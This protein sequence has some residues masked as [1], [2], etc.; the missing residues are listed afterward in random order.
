MVGKAELLFLLNDP[1]RNERDNELDSGRSLCKVDDCDEPGEEDDASVVFLSSRVVTNLSSSAKSA[2]L[3]E[4]RFT[5]VETLL[6]PGGAVPSTS[7]S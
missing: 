3:F 5:L 2:L 4:V 6:F 7:E 1:K